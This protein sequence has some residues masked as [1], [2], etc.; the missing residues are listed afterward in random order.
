VDVGVALVA[1]D[2]CSITNL[3]LRPPSSLRSRPPSTP[4]NTRWVFGTAS[5]NWTLRFS[6]FGTL[7]ASGVLLARAM[8]SA[9]SG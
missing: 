2:G 5:M 6:R 9:R 7:I 1:L 8:P 4:A 3:K